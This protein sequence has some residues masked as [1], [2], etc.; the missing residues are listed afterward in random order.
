M[1]NYNLFD[2]LMEFVC[3][4]MGFCGCMKRGRSLHVTDFI[5][6]DGPVTADQFVEWVFLADNMNPNEDVNKWQPHKEKLHSAFVRI[7]G[8][9]IVDANA[10][11]DG[12]RSFIGPHQE[13]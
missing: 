3:V 10:L 2:E 11:Q 1:K 12:Y 6:E 7:M 13:D 9:E 8:G 5:P 4:R